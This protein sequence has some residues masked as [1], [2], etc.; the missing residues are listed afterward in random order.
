MPEACDPDVVAAAPWRDL[1]VWCPPD[2]P[3]CVQVHLD[4]WA[5]ASLG[6][7]A[8]HRHEVAGYELAQ[9]NEVAWAVLG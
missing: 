1:A 9:S 3:A 6:S 5:W 2:C 7:E 8:Y 4:V